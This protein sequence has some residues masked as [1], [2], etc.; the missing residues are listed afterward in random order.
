MPSGTGLSPRAIQRSSKIEL[1]MGCPIPCLEFLSLW[2]GERRIFGKHLKATVSHSYVASKHIYASLCPQTTGVHSPQ[3]SWP[4]WPFTSASVCKYC[5]C[6][7]IRACAQ[8]FAS[9][10]GPPSQV[11]FRKW[12]SKAKHLAGCVEGTMWPAS[13]H[14]LS[15]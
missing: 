8:N 14:S 5:K 13:S 7:P 6:I 9:V 4:V 10:V 11:C 12:L 1:W 15:Y 2:R 3:S